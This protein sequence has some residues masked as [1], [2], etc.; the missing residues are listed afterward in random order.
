MNQPLYKS[1]RQSFDRD[2]Y[3]PQC[4]IQ[5]APVVIS[6]IRS[7]EDLAAL[8]GAQPPQDVILY[9]NDALSVSSASGEPLLSLYDAL[10]LCSRTVP[11]LFFSS[12]AAAANL[13]RFTDENNLA[14]AILCTTYENR[15]LLRAAYEKM[16]LLRG[17]L[18]CR[19]TDVSTVKLGEIVKNGATALILSPDAVTE[20]RVHFFNTRFV[21][22]IT[23]DDRGFDTTAAD[24]VNGIITADL[25]GAYAFLCRFSENAVLRRKKLV[26]HKGFT[27]GGRYPDNTTDAT[28]ASGRNHFDAVEIDVKLTT[29]D[30]IIVTHNPTTKGEF[31]GD[32]IA[33]EE[34]DYETISRL[35]RTHHPDYTGM[36]RFDDLMRAMKSYPETPLVVEF[37]PGAKYHSIERMIRIA[38]EIFRDEASQQDCVSIMCTLDPGLKYVHDHIPYMPLSHCEG[39]KTV[40]E[41]PKTRFEAEDRLYRVALLTAGCAAGYNCEESRISRLFNEYAKFRMLTVFPWSFSWTKWENVGELND[42]TYQAGYVMWTT[43]H[44]ERY[45]HL[46]VRITAIPPCNASEP[47]TPRALMHFR[48]GSTKETDCTLLT[49]SGEVTAHA[50]GRFSVPSSARVMFALKLDLHFGDSYTIYTAPLEL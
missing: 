23:S 35:R 17:M 10:R 29:D 4:G 28:V 7:A 14:D 37:K 6:E 2:I 24:G 42:A 44:G 31:E 30:T 27:E 16:P 41:A 34:H 47:F 19:A 8:S 21:H 5:A 18:D 48:D 45:M 40:P 15:A 12:E 39:G 20:E 43:D 38:D 9:I 33:P 46:P 49:L 32:I 36:D 13:T 25:A 3:L 26:A 11:I 22:I 1:L 50:D